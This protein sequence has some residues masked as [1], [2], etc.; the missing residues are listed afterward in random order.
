MEI[1]CAEFAEIYESHQHTLAGKKYED[2]KS[3]HFQTLNKESMNFPNATFKHKDI[4]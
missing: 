4:L 1:N 2:S 3:A